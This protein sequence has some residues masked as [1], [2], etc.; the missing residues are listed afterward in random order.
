MLLVG[1]AVNRK[2]FRFEF[3]GKTMMKM[4][5]SQYNCDNNE[6]LFLELPLLA[7]EV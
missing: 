5:R 1:S 3:K 2:A 7:L 4:I 6:E